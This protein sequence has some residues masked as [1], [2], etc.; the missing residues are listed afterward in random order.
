MHRLINPSE[1]LLLNTECAVLNTTCAHSKS[2]RV[3][4]IN[5]LKLHIVVQYLSCV[6]TFTFRIHL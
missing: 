2:M 5:T 6:F 1:F 3:Y 4:I